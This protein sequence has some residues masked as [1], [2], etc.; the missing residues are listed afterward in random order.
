MDR[1]GWHIYSG[2]ERVNETL[3]DPGWADTAGEQRPSGDIWV[4]GTR[5][6]SLRPFKYSTTGLSD[7]S[8]SMVTRVGTSPSQ[9]DPHCVHELKTMCMWGISTSIA[10]ASQTDVKIMINYGR[11]WS[12]RYLTSLLNTPNL[13]LYLCPPL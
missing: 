10:L 8:S 13:Y 1:E 9:E 11:C 5:M 7:C 4:A 2:L 12:I 3:H 6:R